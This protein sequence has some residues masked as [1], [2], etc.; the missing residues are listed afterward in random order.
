MSPGGGLGVARREAGLLAM[1]S[2][3]FIALSA[4]QSIGSIHVLHA[5]FSY[6]RTDIFI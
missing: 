4:S 2:V 1:F 3:D 6:L 5:K